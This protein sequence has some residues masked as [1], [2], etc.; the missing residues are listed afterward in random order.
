VCEGDHNVAAHILNP[1]G[2]V[3][4]GKIRI[5]K[6]TRDTETMEVCVKHLNPGRLEIGC[7]KPRSALIAGRNR[8]SFVN[9]A[10]RTIHFQDRIRSIRRWIPSR[11]SAVFGGEQE[12]GW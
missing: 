9:R 2:S 11:N 8:E 3:I 7:V 6:T 12:N 5:E 1:E 4:R 10:P